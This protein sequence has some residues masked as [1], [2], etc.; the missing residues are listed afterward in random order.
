MQAASLIF[1]KTMRYIKKIIAVPHLEFQAV[2][3]GT[4]LMKTKIT[5]SPSLALLF[6]TYELMKLTSNVHRN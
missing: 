1:S 5:Q 4:R 3:L 6:G 2:I